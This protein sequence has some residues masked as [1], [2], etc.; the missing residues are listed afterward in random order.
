V[1]RVSYSELAQHI[2]PRLFSPA[3]SIDHGMLILQTL[4]D[5]PSIFFVNGQNEVGDH[6]LVR[7]AKQNIFVKLFDHIYC[8]SFACCFLPLILQMLTKNSA[9]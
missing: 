4:V 7:A 5:E 9:R 8:G 6:L 2:A 3:W 1:I